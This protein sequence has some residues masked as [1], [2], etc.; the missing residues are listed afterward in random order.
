MTDPSTARNGFAKPW[1]AFVSGFQRCFVATGSRG[2]AASAVML[3]AAVSAG[4]TS[5]ALR[6]PPAEIF[7]AAVEAL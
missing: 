3:A 5:S 6:V 2:S 1:A 7:P 4:V